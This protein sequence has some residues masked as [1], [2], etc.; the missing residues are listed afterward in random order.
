MFVEEVRLLVTLHFQH[1][2]LN[3]SSVVA[4]VS[5]PSIPPA[6]LTA[7][8]RTAALEYPI[9]LQSVS[10]ERTMKRMLFA[11]TVRSP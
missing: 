10:P 8:R 4:K 5:G 11:W 3:G 9:D 1:H 2:V 7:R 6:V